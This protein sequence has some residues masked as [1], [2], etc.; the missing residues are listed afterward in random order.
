[1]DIQTHL[2]SRPLIQHRHCVVALVPLFSTLGADE[3]LVCETVQPQR[4]LVLRT[5]LLRR[6]VR[7]RDQLVGLPVEPLLVGSQ[8][9]HAVSLRAR[10]TGLHSFALFPSANSAFYS[11]LSHRLR[12][13]LLELLHHLSQDCVPAQQRSGV[14]HLPAL[15]AAV[16]A[17]LFGPVPVVFNAVQAVTVSTGNGHRV[18][19]H[20]QAH[21]ATKLVLLDR[22]SSCCHY[23]RTPSTDWKG[24][25]VG[26]AHTGVLITAS[27]VS[28]AECQLLQSQEAQRLKGMKGKDRHRLW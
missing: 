26:G 21:R 28:P 2:L 19:Q 23:L 5:Q 8:M 6:L 4:L 13:A 12:S 22:N 10:H 20:L 17:F 3:L 9:S 25:R 14:K 7:G 11:L 16:L 1:M 18:L 27:Q 24:T 15:G